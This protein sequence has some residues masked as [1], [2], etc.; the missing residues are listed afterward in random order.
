[1]TGKHL[2]AFAV[3]EHFNAFKVHSA[4]MGLRQLAHQSAQEL[5]LA[6]CGRP[7][8]LHRGIVVCVTGGPTLPSVYLTS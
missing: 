2:A 4:Q 8:A 1:V 5:D 3:L 7:E 6:L